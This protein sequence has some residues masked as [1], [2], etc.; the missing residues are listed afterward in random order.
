MPNSIYDEIYDDIR[1]IPDLAD[2]GCALVHYALVISDSKPVWEKEQWVFR[3]ANFVTFKVQ[4]A[5]DRSIRICLRGHL[6]E[7]WSFS[8]VKLKKHM[9]DGAY[10]ACKLTDNSQL[11]A[12][13]IHIWTAHDNYRRGRKRIHRLPR[14]DD[15]LLRSNQ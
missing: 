7:F 6:E 15:F 8:N 5:R 4:H 2:V 1:R 10:S 12:I 3:P 14:F 13:S 11:V 9:G